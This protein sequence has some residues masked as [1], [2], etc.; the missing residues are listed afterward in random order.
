MHVAVG[1]P[2]LVAQVVE[3]DHRCLVYA[4]LLQ[5]EHATVALHDHRL[6]VRVVPDAYRVAVAEA[7]YGGGDLRYLLFGVYLGVVG[8]GHE[9]SHRQV[10]DLEGR[11]F[12]HGGNLQNIGCA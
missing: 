12:W 4:Q 2:V 7:L 1:A 11:G 6:A 9:V 8:V 5:R 10:G 3:E